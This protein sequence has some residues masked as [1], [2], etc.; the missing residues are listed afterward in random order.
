MKKLL[1]FL[2]PLFFVQIILA[3]GIQFDTV[4]TN[5]STIFNQA[6]QEQKL[7]FVVAYSTSCHNCQEMQEKVYPAT[8][9]GT[10]FNQKY[11]NVKIDVDR[12]SA[13][14]F[15]LKYGIIAY[16][17]YL[18]LND[19]GEQVHRAMG[20][21]SI[22][23]FIAL[24]EN[25]SSS[26]SQY[27]PLKTR[28]L[29]GDRSA[30]LLKKLTFMAKNLE[31]K[32][33]LDSVHIAYLDTQPN[34]L[35]KD[36]MDI[37]R[38]GLKSIEQ[39]TFPFLIQQKKAFIDTFGAANIHNQIEEVVLN[40]LSISSYDYSKRDFDMALAKAY[41]LKYLPADLFE[42]YWLLFNVNQHMRKNE[43]DAFISSAIRYFDQ[44]PCYNEFLYNNIALSFY[45]KTR[46]KEHLDKALNWALK[47]ISIKDIF[48]FND[49]T[50][51]LY[52][53][54]KNKEKAQEY[55]LKA[56]NQAK[57]SGYDASETISLLKKIEAM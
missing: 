35:T 47:A 4:G 1:S 34:W 18:F 38:I 8:T 12:A 41:A 55:A 28:F 48:P 3:Q 13:T 43:E 40:S 19:K 57:E 49:T 54:L 17:T 15:S 25:S 56:I 29:K 50:A 31:N 27:F 52:F 7:I 22:E 44:Y 53:K 51:A 24:G 42:Q 36:N 30:D 14:D 39:K 9:V 20:N 11:I 33:L 5:W 37:I 32:G 26:E 2:A 10:V 23:K 46:E 45:E 16:P 21:M 6:Q